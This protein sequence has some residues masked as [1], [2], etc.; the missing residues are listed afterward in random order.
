[1]Y[2]LKLQDIRS[3]FSKPGS[4]KTSST[5]SKSAHKD[6]KNSNDDVGFS[7]KSSKR[8][9]VE[10]SSDDEKCSPVKIH[11]AKKINLG[12]LASPKDDKVKKKL[13]D[14]KDIFSSTE[15]VRVPKKKAEKVKVEEISLLF[16][17]DEDLLLQTVIECENNMKN[18]TLSSPKKTQ[19]SGISN[20]SSDT[21][22]NS[23]KEN[24]NDEKNKTPTS[25]EKSK[26]TPDKLSRDDK[27]YR[28]NTDKTQFSKSPKN[29]RERTKSPV[30]ISK[31]DI[32]PVTP[33]VES[34]VRR[35][36]TSISKHNESTAQDD[37][38]RHDRKKLTA[39][40][41]QKYK[42]RTSVIN[43]GSKPLPKVMNV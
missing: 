18:N 27:S 35:S 24:N 9:I 32:I 34:K 42:N 11:V 36:S 37:E 21:I 7:K 26:R 29:E 16:D 31:Q 23:P 17:D 33:D 5:Q 28:K 4:S 30:R 20:R 43:P 15:V 22:K 12:K 10:D 13:I 38:D 2:L 39:I 19:D 8:R 41:Y 6:K 25:H 40:L 3:Y 1:M 14:V